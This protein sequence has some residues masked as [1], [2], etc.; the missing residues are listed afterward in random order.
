MAAAQETRKK[1]TVSPLKPGENFKI[2]TA[3]AASKNP[4][5]ISARKKEAAAIPA[6]AKFGFTPNKENPEI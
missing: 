6:S 5:K 1:T 3:I 4:S 2:K